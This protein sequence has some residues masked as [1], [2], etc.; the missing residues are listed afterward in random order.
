MPQWKQQYGEDHILYID[1]SGI[2]TNET[3]EYGWSP[4]GQ[5]CHAFKSGGHGTRLSMISE[6]R[7]NAPFKFTQPL[8]FHGSCDRNIFV[9]WLEYLLQDLKQKDDQTKS[10]LLI[11]DNASIHKGRVIDD[12]AARYQIRIVYLP[13]YS[14]DLNPIERAWSVLKSKV[15]HMVA[16]NNK[17][18][19]E[20][21]DIVFKM[22]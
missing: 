11:L 5:R 20:A 19:Q 22:M 1:E 16:Q 2:N 9:C 18:F 13:A 17:T 21:L 7:S 12:L 15:R 8:V 4:K 14:P 10:Y 3:A 6:V